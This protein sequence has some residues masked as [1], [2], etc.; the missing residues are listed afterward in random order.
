MTDL[1]ILA[2]VKERHHAG[3]TSGFG[4]GYTWT[5]LGWRGNGGG[6]ES[7]MNAN[8]NGTGFPAGYDGAYA[9]HGRGYG[10]PVFIAREL[11]FGYF[12]YS[13]GN[14]QSEP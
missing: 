4:G 7:C 14:G 10:N 3:K 13:D 2:A 11:R 6:G 1:A 5:S 8:G 9:I 12:G